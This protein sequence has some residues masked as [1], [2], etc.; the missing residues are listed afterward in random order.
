LELARQRRG[1]HLAR[2]V[3]KF[4]IHPIRNHRTDGRSLHRGLVGV[5]AWFN[6]AT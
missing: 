5:A 3:E 4:G 6:E 1:R 2:Q